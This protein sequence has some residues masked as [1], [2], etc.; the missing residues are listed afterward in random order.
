MKNYRGIHQRIGSILGAVG[1]V[2][3]TVLAANAPANAGPLVTIYPN[4][5]N[6]HCGAGGWVRAVQVSAFPGTTNVYRDQNWAP[7]R[8][9]SGQNSRIVAN[10]WCAYWW[11]KSG[12]TF[13]VVQSSAYVVA[14]K[15]YYF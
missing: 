6:H 2:V 14:N 12:S 5:G 13:K 15:S 11:N 7:V 1:I 3:G 8:A 4:Y 9:N 10:V